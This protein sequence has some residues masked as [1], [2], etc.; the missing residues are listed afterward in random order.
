[1]PACPNRTPAARLRNDRAGLGE[2]LASGLAVV[3]E[4]GQAARARFRP[5]ALPQA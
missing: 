5:M 4:L 2:V 3:A 1:L